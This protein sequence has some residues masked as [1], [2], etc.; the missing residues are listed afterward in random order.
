VKRAISFCFDDGFRRSAEVIGEVFVR[1]GLSA[2]FAVL[3]R[4]ERALDRYLRGADLG[5]W[6][7][8]RNVVAMGHEVAPH[9]LMHERY[10]ELS[11]TDVQAS[12]LD[13]L[14]VIESEIPGFSRFE[15]VFHVPYLRAPDQVVAWL[16]TQSLGVRVAGRAAGLNAWTELHPGCPV[17]C[18]C[19]GPDG[20]AESMRTRIAEFAHQEGWLV[21]ALHGVDREGWGSVARADLERLLDQVQ[22]FDCEITPPNRLLSNVLA[23]KPRRGDGVVE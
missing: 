3:S 19:F 16:G 2:C 7:F 6:A 18:I 23:T 4:P 10:D 9:G 5:D 1:R 8:W 22:E 20:V 15:S 12:V 14:D 21:L 11:F 13:A 17:D